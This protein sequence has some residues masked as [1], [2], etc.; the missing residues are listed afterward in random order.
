MAFDLPSGP[1]QRQ[2][3]RDATV[4]LAAPRDTGSPY[5]PLGASPRVLPIRTNASRGEA[6]EHQ[7]NQ[8]KHHR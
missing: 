8:N 7:Q 1:S 3:S 5:S 2:V 4:R 6:N